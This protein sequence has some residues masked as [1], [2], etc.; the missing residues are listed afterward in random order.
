VTEFKIGDEV[1]WTSQSAG[2]KTTK[3]GKVVHVLPAGKGPGK[4]SK[5]SNPGAARDHV[6]Y[7]VRVKGKGLYWPKASY[8]K[9]IKESCHGCGGSGLVRAGSYN[10][11]GTLCICQLKEKV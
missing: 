5:N 7:L 3:R 10:G 9:L 6:S 2:T 11:R 1:E 8:L 4:I